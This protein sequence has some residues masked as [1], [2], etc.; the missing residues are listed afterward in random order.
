MSNAP[1]IRIRAK[2]PAWTPNERLRKIRREVDLSQADFAA[3]I[4]VKATTL[5]AWEAGRNRIPDVLALSELLELEFGYSKYWFRGDLDG[6]GYDGPTP[7]GGLPADKSRKLRIDNS[8]HSVITG[9][10]GKPATRRLAK[11]S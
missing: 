6:D 2:V 11:A 8:R 5:S 4:G 3:R 9:H 1:V 7:D 10:F